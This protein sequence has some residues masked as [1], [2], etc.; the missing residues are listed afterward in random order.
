MGGVNPEHRFWFIDWF[1][2]WEVDRDR[3]PVT[4][5]KH[6]LQ[7]LCHAGI[8]FL[9]R[10]KR[11]HIY[12]VSL[13]RFGRIL[14]LVPPAQKCAPTYHIDDAFQRPVVMGSGPRTGLD[15]DC[16]SPELP[17]SGSCDV[18]GGAPIHAWGRI[19]ARDN[20]VELVGFDNPNTV[21]FPVGRRGSSDRFVFV[22]GCVRACR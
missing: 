10:H 14:E 3:F 11:G 20:G 21:S 2:S 17:G 13:S 12:E 7:C 16:A 1:E 8:E 15:C 18:D 19:G 6:A 9:V 4:T 5:H 22:Q